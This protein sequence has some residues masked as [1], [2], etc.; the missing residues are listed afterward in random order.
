MAIIRVIENRDVLRW[1]SD[2]SM[3]APFIGLTAC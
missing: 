3:Y 1:S 2:Y